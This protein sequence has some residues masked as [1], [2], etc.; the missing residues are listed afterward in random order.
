MNPVESM[1]GKSMT[2]KPNHLSAS[3]H[4]I[5][6]NVDSVQSESERVIK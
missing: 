3:D 5:L 2:A 6:A 1:T 4:P